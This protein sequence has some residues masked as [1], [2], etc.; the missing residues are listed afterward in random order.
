MSDP[1]RDYD[2][3]GIGRDNGNFLGLPWVER[4]AVRFLAAGF[5]VTVSYGTGTEGG[6]DNVLAASR[7]LDVCLPGLEEPWRAGY[8]W[9]SL[10]VGDEADLAIA[11]EAVDDAIA[12]QAAGLVPDAGA[13]AFVEAVGERMLATVEA[14]VADALAAGELP[15]LIGGEHAVSLGALRACAK[16]GAF[17]LLQVDAHMDLRHAYEG[18]RYSHA[19]VMHNALAELPALER[20]T[21]VGIRD[22]S[23]QERARIAAEGGR[24]RTFFDDDLQARVLGGESWRAIV[25]D[26]VATLPARVWVSFDIDGLRPELCANT[27]TPVPGG[28]G[29]AEA[30]YLLRAVVASGR[31]VIGFDVVEVAPAP[32]EFEGAVAARLAYDFAARVAAGVA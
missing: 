7:Q 9:T 15:V 14:A 27:G 21:Q 5:G 26:I 6:P 4:P 19:S 32:H 18:L 22:Y 17:G 12:R 11:R 28:L 10:A 23:P 1:Y 24:L 16:T 2:P 25:A 31:A 8:A 20:L 29:F 3:D 13:L 30:Q